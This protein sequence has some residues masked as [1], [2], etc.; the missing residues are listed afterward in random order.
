MRVDQLRRKGIV[1]DGIDREVAPGGRFRVGERRLRNDSESA[2]AGAGF[3]LATGQAEIVFGAV[4]AELDDAEAPADHV[5]AAKRGEHAMEL[6]ESHAR[7][8]HIEVLR[9]EPEQPVPHAAADQARPPDGAQRL[10][11]GEEVFGKTHDEGG[12][13]TTLRGSN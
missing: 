7:H 3:G 2:V 13:G 8:L 6:F 9:L 12:A 4:D 10:Q 1:G 11:G 5:R